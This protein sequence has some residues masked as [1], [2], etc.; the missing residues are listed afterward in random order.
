MV[1]NHEIA[2]KLARH[3]LKITKRLEDGL[4]PIKKMYIKYFR[5]YDFC[6]FHFNKK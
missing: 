3:Q 5:Y 4:T 6:S 2:E 1:E